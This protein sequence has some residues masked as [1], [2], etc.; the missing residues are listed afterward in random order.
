MCGAGVG[1][2]RLL[3]YTYTVFMYGKIAILMV[4]EV[5]ESSVGRIVVTKY[6]SKYIWTKTRVAVQVYRP[7]LHGIAASVVGNCFLESK[8]VHDSLALVLNIAKWCPEAMGKT[9]VE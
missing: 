3:K 7:T 9:D 6:K 5:Q 1:I 4:F 2:L 8:L